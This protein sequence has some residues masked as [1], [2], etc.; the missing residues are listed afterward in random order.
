MIFKIKTKKDKKI[1]LLENEIELL[2]N[3]IQDLLERTKPQPRLLFEKPNVVTLESCFCVYFEDLDRLPSNYVK[4]HL[5]KELC[6]E[7]DKHIT[8]TIEDNYMLRS[9]LFKA[10]LRI[11]TQ[12]ERI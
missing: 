4:S 12:E 8:I 6:G 9:R 11:L 10:R 1:E 7:L 3:K 2:E 5:S